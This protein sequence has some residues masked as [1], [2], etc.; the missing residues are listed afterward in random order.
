MRVEAKEQSGKCASGQRKREGGMFAKEGA[1]EREPSRGMNLGR[2]PTNPGTNLKQRPLPLRIPARRRW[3]H[4]H[5]PK[6]GE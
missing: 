6:P 2:N 4:L 5:G 1:G 3:I